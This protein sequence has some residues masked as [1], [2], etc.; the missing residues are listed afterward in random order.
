[1][2]D[3]DTALC[4]KWVMHSGQRLGGRG[5]PNY[6]IIPKWE[7]SPNYPAFG[8]I[9]KLSSDCRDADRSRWS[10]WFSVM[11]S[12]LYLLSIH[13]LLLI[14]LVVLEMRIIG[15]KKSDYGIS[16]HRR[17]VTALAEVHIVGLGS[18]SRLWERTSY[19]PSC[20][21]SKSRCY[22]MKIDRSWGTA[23][24]AVRQLCQRQKPQ[25]SLRHV[26]NAM[27]KLGTSCL[28]LL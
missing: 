21:T 11:R 26:S 5:P 13:Y 10:Y 23:E 22:W 8:I 24:A 14:A 15:C 27:I 17:V 7:L 25:K 19:A 28:F 18:D 1:M 20:L 3:P 16:I 6:G 9:L 12:L 2:F 4:E